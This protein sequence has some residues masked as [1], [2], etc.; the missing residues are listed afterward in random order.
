MDETRNR[1]RARLALWLVAVG[2]QC[3]VAIISLAWPG[4]FGYSAKVHLFGDVR[5]YHQ[6]VER[7]VEGNLPYRD[8]PVE[9][10]ILAIPI[11]LIP[12][13]AGQSFEAYRVAFV[14]LM[15]AI[16][17]IAVW[18]VARRVDETEGPSRVA[19]RLAWY[20]VDFA[21]LCPMI[22]TRFDLV[23]M[24]L[25][26]AATLAMTRGRMALGGLISGLGVLVKIVPGLVIVPFLA[27]PVGLRSKIK[28]ILGVATTVGLG[29]LIWWGLAGD[30]LLGMFRY[31]SDRGIEIES[32]YGSAYLVAH[33]LFGILLIN[34][35]DHGSMNLYADGA[36]DAASLSIIL[37]GLMLLLVAGKAEEAGRGHE[38]RFATASLLAYLIAG[39]V[40]S[41]QYLIWLIPFVCVLEGQAGTWARWIFLPCCVLTTAL[42]PWLFRSLIEFHTAPVIVLVIRNLAL[43]ALFAVL[44]QSRTITPTRSSPAACS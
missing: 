25:A 27:V 33:K 5:I 21:A 14:G 18:L 11:F 15:L 41:P 6:Y 30:R 4:W 44:L 16:N 13:L 43:V 22:V 10:P 38:F 12:R 35:F 32:L 2:F 8:F 26:F 37:Q 36:R 1:L 24:L 34:H 7:I 9:Y 3:L 42:F 28:V 19:G 39:K 40:L 29:L 17:A 31:H 23:P 20:S